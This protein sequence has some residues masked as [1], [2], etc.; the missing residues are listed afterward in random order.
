MAATASASPEL[1]LGEDAVRRVAPRRERAL[2]VLPSL[3]VSVIAVIQI[4]LSLS[5]FAALTRQQTYG[6]DFSAFYVG[7]VL[8]RDGQGA[9]LYD[10]TSQVQVR[11]QIG[12]NYWAGPLPFVYP[13]SAAIV[14]MPLTTL[15]LGAADRI[16]SLI[17]LGLVA[18]AAVVVGR[19]APWP[20]PSRRDLPAGTGWGGGIGRSAVAASV[21]AAIAGIGTAIMLLEGQPTG[22]LALGLALAY[23][24]WTSG[25]NG[26]AA[27]SIS[28]AFFALKPHLAI[29]LV[30]YMLALHNRRALLGLASGAMAVVALSLAVAGPAGVIGFLTA[31]GLSSQVS[32]LQTMLGFTG[33]AGSQF[34]PGA[35]TDIVAGLL[36][37]AAVAGCWFAGRHA[38]RHPTSIEVPLAVAAVLS[39]LLAPHLLVHD[40]VILAPVV[41]WCLAAA[42][43][44]DVRR[45][46]WWPG[47]A[48]LVVLSLWLALGW[49]A[50][51]PQPEAMPR[52]L[53]PYL[54]IAA[55]VILAAA[56]YRQRDPRLE[57]TSA[58]AR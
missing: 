32:A 40:L 52:R 51:G 21:L 11:Q 22:I 50:R 15:P 41:V 55:V 12:G 45:T 44:S 10:A 16:W 19:K 26:L 3:L 30:I 8:L 29:G 2:R 57:R 53:V 4:G 5:A 48:G 1:I 39:L 33:L 46:S 54:L 14:V 42:A 25:H 56:A 9:H 7:A 34:G 13:P 36:S 47:A 18:A 37:L 28:V 6:T 17:Q 38:R 49:A 43:R 35:L 58:A 24:A 31:P 23:V 27:L 20:H